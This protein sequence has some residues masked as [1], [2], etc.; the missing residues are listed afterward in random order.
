MSLSMDANFE[1]QLL[2]MVGMPRAGTT[3]FY[4]ALQSH[5]SF[6]VPY[7]KELCYFST[8]YKNGG[9]W[10]RSLFSGARKDQFCADISPDY[11]VHPEAIER[12]L[13]LSSTPKIL[14]AV[15][16]PATWAVSYHRHLQT[17]QWKVPAFEQFLNQHSVPDN[18]LL[19]STEPQK[20]QTFSISQGLVSRQIEHYRTAFG[21]SLVIYSFEWFGENPLRL[22]RGLELAWSLPKAFTASA[23]P[24]KA[25][26]SSNRRNSKIL[27]YVISRD[28][29]A[30][31][32]ASIIPRG[33]LMS[34]RRRF[35]RLSVP[36]ASQLHDRDYESD[37]KIARSAVSKDIT[38]CEQ[39]FSR[40]KLQFGDGT[41]VV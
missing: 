8:K 13:K 4:D 38:Y 40:H 17:F 29:I 2:I 11:F 25:I 24:T 31:A 21:K 12:I 6:F 26:N 14:L 35:D 27:S 5:P 18:S 22:F 9:H 34:L 37:L 15:R 36:K 1:K 28:E 10:Y 16:N 32:I 23:I 33:P 30:S 19:R 7:R 3:F 41:P 39:L 20:Q